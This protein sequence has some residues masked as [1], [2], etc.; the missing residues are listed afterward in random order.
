MNQKV[1]IYEIANNEQFEA[2][3]NK[4]I[5]KTGAKVNYVCTIHS[6]PVTPVVMVVY[7]MTN[8]AGHLYSKGLF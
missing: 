2:E 5:S 6:D 8:S 3:V 1:K 4:F 7:E